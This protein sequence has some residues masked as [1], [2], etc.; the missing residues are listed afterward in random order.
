[1]SLPQGAETYEEA[2]RRI[3]AAVDSGNSDLRA[4]GFWRLLE[5]VKAEPALA[6][7]SRSR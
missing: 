4:L 3:E 5:R 1:M 6:R 7:T 2:F